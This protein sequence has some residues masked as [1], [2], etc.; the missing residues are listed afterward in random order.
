MRSTQKNF[1]ILCVSLVLTISYYGCSPAA[2]KLSPEQ[3][4]S[5]AEKIQVNGTTYIQQPKVDILFVVDRSGS[6]NSYQTNL[7]QNI[8]LFLNQLSYLD[9]D[10]QIGVLTSDGTLPIYVNYHAKLQGKVKIVTPSTPDALAQIKNNIMVGSLGDSREVFFSPIVKALSPHYLA[11]GGV[12]QGFIREKAH[13]AIVFLTDAEEQ[14]QN[15]SPQDTF[16]FLVDLKKSKNKVLS[17]GIIIPSSYVGGSGCLRDAGEPL[18][19]EEFLLKTINGGTKKNV[20]NICSQT[21]GNDLLRISKDLTRFLSGTIYLSQR[22]VLS[23]MSVYYNGIQLKSD[24]SN[25]WFYDPKIN[26]VIIGNNVDLDNYVGDGSGMKVNFSVE[27][28]F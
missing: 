7:S 8:D 11:V 12:N 21:F 9:V 14:S 13:L 4:F 22:P 2:P 18:R 19:F 16:D 28:S 26:A 23:T 25:G 10:Y 3:K 5:E 6:M 17:Y 15:I 24:F 1:F 27:D 20:M